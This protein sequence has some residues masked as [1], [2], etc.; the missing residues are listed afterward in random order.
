MSKS[1]NIS[2]VLN[3]RE[4]KRSEKSFGIETILKIILTTERLSKGTDFQDGTSTKLLIY[5]QANGAAQQIRKNAFKIVSSINLQVK[6]T[7]QWIYT[8]FISY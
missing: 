7:S 6:K 8:N 1:F 4:K 2:D 5:L 3:E